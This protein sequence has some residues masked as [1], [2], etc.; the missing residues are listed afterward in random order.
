[1]AAEAVL[2][3]LADT[4]RPYSAND[5]TQNL[6]KKFGKT[7]ILRALDALVS[8]EQIMEKVY[9][10]Q[11][12]YCALQEDDDKDQVFLMK[13]YFNS[14]VFLNTFCQVIV[15]IHQ[16]HIKSVLICYKYLNIVVHG[17]YFDQLGLLIYQ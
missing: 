15:R 11:K 3:Y 17:L 6:N 2:K 16:K 4:N 5:I 1:M 10:K 13:L 7:E 9:G 12:V 14:R 8:K